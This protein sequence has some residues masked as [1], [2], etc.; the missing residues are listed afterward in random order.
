M[1]RVIIYKN[2]EVIDGKFDI[3]VII[4]CVEVIAIIL[5]GEYV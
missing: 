5:A 4:S 2:N 3:W 1:Y